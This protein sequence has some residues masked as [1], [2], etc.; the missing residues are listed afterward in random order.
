MII[1]TNKNHGFTIV[2]LLIVIVVIGILAAISIVSYNGIQNRSKNAQTTSALNNWVKGLQMYKA[3]RGSWP[4][5]WVCLGEN[6]KYGLSGQDPTG[7][8]QCRQ[9][10][11]SGY[12]TNST[13]N[14]AMAPYIQ[15]QLPTPAFV[16][17]TQD[18]SNWRRGLMYAFAGGSGGTVVYIDAALAGELSRCP[19]V[20]GTLSSTRSLWGGNTM[21]NYTLGATTDS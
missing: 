8:A 3:D 2:E 21:C 14:T 6:Y 19:D 11:T 1:E 4:T 18:T 13:F 16:T 5:G 15:G 12:T 7:S 20:G 9:T 10:G 17:A